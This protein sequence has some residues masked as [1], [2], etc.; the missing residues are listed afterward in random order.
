M[1]RNSTRKNAIRKV[2]PMRLRKRGFRV[3]FKNANSIR[4]RIR[5]KAKTLLF[6]AWLYLSLPREEY[7]EIVGKNRNDL[8]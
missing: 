7:S 2:L 1:G 6:D 8:T 5:I 3:Q 4:E